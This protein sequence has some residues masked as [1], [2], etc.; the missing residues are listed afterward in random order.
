MSR[1]MHSSADEIAELTDRV[2]SVGG[3]VEKLVKHATLAFLDGCALESVRV[4]D[5]RNQI[6][7][8]ELDLADFA[9]T[10]LAQREPSPSD[11]R[12]IVA[13]LE[14]ADAYTRIA[15]LWMEIAS[16]PQLAKLLPELPELDRA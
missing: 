2:V 14:I 5:K 11:V 8:T 16:R 10:L 15:D 12:A 7:E 9:L 3:A 13:S 1:A 4:A 6:S